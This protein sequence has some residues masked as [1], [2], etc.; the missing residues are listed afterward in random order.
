[1]VVMAHQDSRVGQV[2]VAQEETVLA[3]TAMNQTLR[4]IHPRT[5]VM[6]LRAW[7]DVEENTEHI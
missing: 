2:A 7:E 1:M 4:S 6:G 3:S 5:S